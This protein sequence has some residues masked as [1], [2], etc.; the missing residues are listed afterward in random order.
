LP[1]F[2]ALPEGFTPFGAGVNLQGEINNVIAHTVPGTGPP[3]QQG[4]FPA[5]VEWIRDTL[6]FNAGRSFRATALVDRVVTE[7]PDA[8]P[9]AIR[10]QIEHADAEPVT[11][12]LPYHLKDGVLERGELSVVAGESLVFGKA[13]TEK[14]ERASDER[15]GQELTK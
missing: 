15:E 4:Y 6:A 7:P 3:D 5:P 12:Y 14:D 1:T 8:G 2:V 10:V 11:C 13:A 9:P